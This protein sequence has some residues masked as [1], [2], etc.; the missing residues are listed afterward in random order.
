MLVD[1]L[2]ESPA[3]TI[4]SV[5]DERTVV[6]RKQSDELPSFGAHGESVTFRHVPGARRAYA[7]TRYRLLESRLGIA[8]RN[9]A[10]GEKLARRLRSK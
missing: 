10:A 5:L 8:F 2:R 6:A 7:A 4:E 9:T 3:W 1:H